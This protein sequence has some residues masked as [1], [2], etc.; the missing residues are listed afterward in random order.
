MAVSAMY[1]PYIHFR[2]REWLRTAML[3]Y[4]E[5]TRI[6]PEGI[7]T[8]DVDY[9]SRFST[10]PQALSEEVT[11]LSRVGFIRDA[12]PSS[13]INSLVA[14]QFVDRTSAILFDPQK[15]ST[16]NEIISRKLPFRIHPS[17]IDPDLLRIFEETQVATRSPGDRYS[18]WEIE[19]VTGSL[20][21]LALASE[22]AGSRPLVSDTVTFQS[23]LFSRIEDTHPKPDTSFRLASTAI[24]LV[25]PSDIEAVP[26]D[27]LLRLREDQTKTR[28]RFQDQ[29]ARMSKDIETAKSPTELSDGLARA[30][31]QIEDEIETLKEKVNSAGLTASLSILSVSVPTAINT[32]FS[33]GHFWPEIV[34]GLV[35]FGVSVAAMK[36]RWEKRQLER[37][38]FNYLIK[39][40]DLTNP[41]TLTEKIIRLDLEDDDD[42]RVL[43][44]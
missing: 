6:V 13:S 32:A 8:E 7:S 21:M 30:Q 24:A 19:P 33:Q 38:P 5:L 1:Y 14:N 22:M 36:Y 37:N 17:K 10:S 15:R 11:E 26:L 27:K 39:L 44:Y 16:M 2:S 41:L 35:T 3:Y 9:Y 28:Q 18:D 23:L 42:G 20:Y 34:A 29:V 31:R 43:A 40:G 12:H 25:T 4:D